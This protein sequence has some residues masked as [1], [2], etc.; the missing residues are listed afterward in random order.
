M[1]K[2]KKKKKPY[3]E[4]LW[5]SHLR[6]IKVLVAIFRHYGPWNDLSNLPKALISSCA[7]AVGDKAYPGIATLWIRGDKDIRGLAFEL[8]SMLH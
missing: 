4:E 2:K 6:V 8:Q 7:E 3:F 5:F 1:K